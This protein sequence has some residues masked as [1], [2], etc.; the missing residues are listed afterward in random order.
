MQHPVNRLTAVAVALLWPALAAEAGHKEMLFEPLAPPRSVQAVSELHASI[1][2][3]PHTAARVEECI[4]NF[5]E[6]LHCEVWRTADN[7]HVLVRAEDL[8]EFTGK[9]QP[10][11]E[12]SLARIRSLDAGVRFAGRFAGQRFLSLDDCL[13]LARGRINLI[14]N[15]RDAD[16]ELLL[17]QIRTAE[18]SR[19]VVISGVPDVIR[20]VHSKASGKMALMA[21]LQNEQQFEELRTAVDLFAAELKPEN[22]T[23]ELCGVLRQHQLMIC[24]KASGTPDDL[25]ER[26]LQFRSAGANWI[27]TERPEELTAQS[28]RL[29]VQKMPIRIA[30]HRGACQYAPENTLAALRK[31]IALG[32][33]YVEL[34][35]RTTRDGVPVVLHDSSLR[36]TTEVD[37]RV[38]ELALAEVR[39][40]D[41]G[42]WFSKAFQTETLPTLDAYLEAVGPSIELYV[43]AKD[44]APELLVEALKRHGLIQRSVVYQNADYLYRLMEIEP[45]LRRMPPLRSPEAVRETIDRVRPWAFDARWSI[46]SAE[47]IEQCHRQGV[48]VFSDAL[49]LNEEIPR[50]QKA[51]RDGIDVIQTD[52]P[53]RVLRAVE[54]MHEK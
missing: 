7:E 29:Q 43:D 32:A 40:L 54:L 5:S 48:L 39:S 22:V 41:A 31:A 16:P 37:R 50:Y 24:V 47:L 20:T 10:V 11:R 34:D 3:P 12:L 13:T 45:T 9:A 14:L 53:L 26:W 42:S 8:T 44:I 27:R 21:L 28:I 52:H 35:I 25:P 19:Q 46:L 2:T 17:Q 38:G 15:V 23:P 1:S 36:R 49:D 6:W 30:C 4:R 33:D 51:V 18:M